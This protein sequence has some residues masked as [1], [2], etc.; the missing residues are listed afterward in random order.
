MAYADSQPGVLIQAFEGE[1]AVTKD[2]NLLGKGRPSQLLLAVRLCTLDGAAAAAAQQGDC[3]AVA[4]ASEAD[5]DGD[6]LDL[7]MIMVLG[8]LLLGFIA[9]FL[10]ARWCYRSVAP[11][12]TTPGRTMST[13]SQVTFRRDL[14]APR[15]QPLPEW[16]QGAWD[17]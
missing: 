13:Q 4:L 5:V 10:A 16:G 9:G 8:V 7:L 6:R 15:M 14:A 2:N 3:A 11:T 17:H 1:R 12:G